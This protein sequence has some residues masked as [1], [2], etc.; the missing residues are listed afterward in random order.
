MTALRAGALLLAVSPAVALSQAPPPLAGPRAT[1]DRFLSALHARDFAGLR[2]LYAD[3]VRFDD[4][5]IGMSVTGAD[6]VIAQFAGGYAIVRQFRWHVDGGFTTGSWVV[7]HGV[8]ASELEGA[9]IGRPGRNPAGRQRFVS[10]FDV[11][12]D[13]IVRQLDFLDYDAWDRE[14]PDVPVPVRRRSEPPGVLASLADRF[15]AGL[16][17][18][19]PSVDAAMD[20]YT[21]DLEFEDPTFG[22]EQRTKAAFRAAVADLWAKTGHVEARTAIEDRILSGAFVILRGV[23]SQKRSPAAAAG[24]RVSMAFVTALEV[25]DGRIARHWDFFDKASFDRQLAHGR[26]PRFRRDPSGNTCAGLGVQG[27]IGEAGTVIRGRVPGAARPRTW[28]PAAS[29]PRAAG[30]G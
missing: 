28:P 29:R 26:A 10:A 1:V 21:D 25:R 7:L 15:V 13:R 23:Y 17:A 9:R 16:N 24:D 27:C 22:F 30:V 6:R 12:E 2:R 14:H 4:P 18:W 11:R 19:P 3:A 5:T 20:L 8:L